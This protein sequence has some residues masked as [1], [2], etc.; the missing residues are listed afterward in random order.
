MSNT[1]PS[2]ADAKKL[3]A[4]LAGQQA[5]EQAL[6][7]LQ[8]QG[9]TLRERNFRCKTGEIDLIMQHGET[10]VFVE[11]KYRRSTQY[12]G[13]LLSIS[14]RQQQRIIKTA[15]YYLMRQAPYAQARFDVIALEGEN[16]LHWLPNAFTTDF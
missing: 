2:A 15:S 3:A 13:A 5:E 9:L 11:V 14:A 8:Q 1:K 10:V 16:N 6:V 4:V 7:Y 12:G